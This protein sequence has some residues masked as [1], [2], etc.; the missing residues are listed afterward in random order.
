MLVWTATGQPT[1][2]APILGRVSSSESGGAERILGRPLGKF[3]WRLILECPVRAI[4]I[5]LS[6]PSLNALLGF[7]KRFE[8]A[9]IETFPPDRRV[10]GF[11]ISVVRGLFGS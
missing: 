3:G 8:P 6:P 9:H 5:I 10:E 11:H 1:I 2:S 7:M 4:L